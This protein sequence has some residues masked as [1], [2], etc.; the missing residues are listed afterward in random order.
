MLH[1]FFASVVFK[2]KTQ[3][4]ILRTATQLTTHFSMMKMERTAEAGALFCLAFFQSCQQHWLHMF[5]KVAFVLFSQAPAS[6]CLHTGFPGETSYLSVQ[7]VFDLSLKEK[8]TIKETRTTKW[9][10]SALIFFQTLPSQV[11]WRRPAGG[12]I[13][14]TICRQ[15]QKTAAA[16]PHPSCLLPV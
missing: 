6:I 8:E 2:T 15:M 3:S 11:A 12:L 10:A 16:G 5:S 9:Q 4:Q 13:F 1:L 7:D 14:R